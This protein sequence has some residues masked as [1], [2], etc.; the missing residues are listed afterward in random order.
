MQTCGCILLLLSLFVDGHSTHQR[1]RQIPL[2]TLA[3]IHASMGLPPPP[4]YHP[5]TP[6]KTA[7][8]NP[9]FLHDVPTRLQ[10]RYASIGHALEHSSA[11]MRFRS[12]AASKSGTTSG[13]TSST[14][15][16]QQ[17]QQKDD[18]IQIECPSDTF[19][20]PCSDRGDCDENQGK[21]TCTGAATTLPPSLFLQLQATAL[22]SVLTAPTSD[23]GGGG[24]Q[25]YGPGCEFTTCPSVNSQVCNGQGTCNPSKG[26]CQC[27]P[28]WMGDAC[29][30]DPN[31]L[32]V[33]QEDCEEMGDQ[34]IAECIRATTTGSCN[35]YKLTWDR[36][37]FKTC[38]A[39]V[40]KTC[41]LQKR[42][43]FC[44]HSPDCEVLCNSM[45][46]VSCNRFITILPSSNF[47][48]VANSPPANSNANTTETKERNETKAVEKEEAGVGSVV[49]S[50]SAAPAPST[51]KSNILKK[52]G[53]AVYGG[54]GG[55]GGSKSGYRQT[56]SG[57]ETGK[58]VEKGEKKE[59]KGA[60]GRYVHQKAQEEKREEKE[61]K[62]KSRGEQVDQ[63]KQETHHSKK[64]GK[65]GQRSPTE[66]N[67]KEI[68]QMNQAYDQAFKFKGTRGKGSSSGGGGGGLPIQDAFSFVE[69]RQDDGSR[70]RSRS[71]RRKGSSFIDL[72]ASTNT[73]GN[74]DSSIDSA[75][76]HLRKRRG[77][78]EQRMTRKLGFD[79][80]TYGRPTKDEETAAKLPGD[81]ATAFNALERDQQFYSNRAGGLGSS[82]N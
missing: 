80:M 72:E 21:C 51:Q 67:E 12:G 82:N 75:L 61:E 42:R 10:H 45:M 62:E 18:P 38:V 39:L 37:C 26:E 43:S 65:A 17:R 44:S 63:E 40:G 29:A 28:G 60:I 31:S 68:D 36:L 71:R 35:A 1:H 52:T 41:D 74:I 5:K 22:D 34:Y 8:Q 79:V 47:D 24:G 32:N 4:G 25:S 23:G 6:D 73:I 59:H 33:F 2:E 58:T 11:S 20:R 48:T 78:V 50:E 56:K 16:Q 13:A 19:G 69:L 55:R 9:S 7:I 81:Y 27:F 46:D 57:S 70:R 76:L 77:V 54:K 49:G 3:K 66:R 53:Q 30:T 64:T 15:A 14:T